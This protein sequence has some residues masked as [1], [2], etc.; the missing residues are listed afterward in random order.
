MGTTYVDT[1]YHGISAVISNLNVND[2][3]NAA[4]ALRDTRAPGI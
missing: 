3:G 2:T 4:S 1:V